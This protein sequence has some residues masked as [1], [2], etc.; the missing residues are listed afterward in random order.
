MGIMRNVSQCL[1]AMAVALA[2]A[3][4]GPSGTPESRHAA[5]KTLFEET[6]RN[7]HLPSA[8]VP[9]AEAARL[10]EKTASGYEKLLRQYHDQPFWCAQ[11]L[12]SLGNVRAAQGRLEDAI[13]LYR[14]VGQDYPDQKWE[15][16][17]A[18]KSAGDLLWEAKRVEEARAFYQQ[19]ITQFDQTG[20]PQVVQIVLRGAR[21]RLAQGA[22]TPKPAK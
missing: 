2:L 7:F 15:V 13:R 6:T 19:L 20:A 22:S 14:Q 3:G 12:R 8:E 16:L 10:L 11:A 4:C 18:M 5:A 17:Q 9:P 21:S 1:M